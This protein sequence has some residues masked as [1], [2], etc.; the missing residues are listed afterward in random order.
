M[1]PFSTTWTCVTFN[2][3]GQE[4]ADLCKAAVEKSGDQREGCGVAAMS[5]A[6]SLGSQVPE[7]VLQPDPN[8]QHWRG[9]QAERGKVLQMRVWE[10]A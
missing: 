10:I 6:S 4:P 2:F 9:S 5:G 1:N 3:A 7:A 8:H